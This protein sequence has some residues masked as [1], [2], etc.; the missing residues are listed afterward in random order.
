[1]LT[2]PRHLVVS[3][4]EYLR[5]PGLERHTLNVKSF[6]ERNTHRHVWPYQRLIQHPIQ[7]FSQLR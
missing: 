7:P 3:L 2:Y 1:M 5:A 4:A 6:S